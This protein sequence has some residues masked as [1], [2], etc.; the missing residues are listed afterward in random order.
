MKKNDYILL[1]S[2]VFYTLLL[3][4]QLPGINFLILNILLIGFLLWRNLTLLK[5]TNWVLTAIGSIATA[6]CITWHGNFL[7][8]L[9][10]IISLS[11]LSGLSFNTRSSVIFSFLF[12]VY[13]YFSS[14]V[15]MALAYID[16]RRKIE[17]EKTETNA[18]Y[19][20][21]L[22]LGIPVVIFLI[23]FFMY[24]AANPVFNSFAEKLNLDFISLDWIR[25]TLG[26][27]VLMYGFWYHKE[28]P[29]LASKDAS[30][31][32][33]IHPGQLGKPSFLGKILGLANENL[34]GIILLSLLILLL[35]TVNVLDIQY[36]FLG[37][38]LPETLSYSEFVH[39]GIGMLITSII[40]AILIILYYFRGNLN[41]FENNK[42][43]KLLAYLWII[44]NAFMIISTAYRNN[45]YI[46]EYSLTYKRIGVYIYL[47]LALIGL[48]TTLIK[49]AKVK[50]NW[51]LFR[52]NSWMFYAVLVISCF[53][54]WDLLITNFNINRAEKSGKFLDKDYL[55]KLSYTNIP[56][57][58]KMSDTVTSFNSNYIY[59]DEAYID[60][61]ENQNFYEQAQN[62]DAGIEKFR[63]LVHSKL[64]AFFSE[65]NQ[66]DWRSWSYDRSKT[67]KDIKELVKKVNFESVNLS[68]NN[69]TTIDPFKDFTQ[70]REINFANNQLSQL[71]SLSYFSNL[72]KLD[73][74]NNQIDSLTTLPVLNKLEELNLS[75]NSF[76]DLTP[77]K[78]A[79]A[80]RDLNIANNKNYNLN[81]IFPKMPDLKS[82]DISGNRITDLKQLNN[83]PNL[84]K[85]VINDNPE[86]NLQEIPVL[87]N[88]KVLHLK[89]S[90]ISSDNFDIRNKIKVFKNLRELNISNNNLVTI[91]Y[92]NENYQSYQDYLKDSSAL[93][94]KNF[95]PVFPDLEVLNISSNKLNKI[96]GIDA[97]KK[98]KTLNLQNTE[99]TKLEPLAL[100]PELKNLDVSYNSISIIEPLRTMT[101]LE[102]LNLS[103]NLVIVPENIFAYHFK[104]S[105]LNLSHTN[106]GKINYISGTPAL[107]V[108]NV[109]NTYLTSLEGI[110]NI[111][112]IEIL[113]ISG[114]NISDF[115]PL[116][117]LKNLKELYIGKITD[118]QL[119][120]LK[121]M[122]PK[123]KIFHINR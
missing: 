116:Y 14:I 100:L 32:N 45:L 103:H 35:L 40:C 8:F 113:D 117:K 31:T 51:Y 49:I 1:I 106:L 111:K 88:L 48:A 82:L 77:L 44:Q 75:A 43:L 20:K 22:M 73:L 123:L 104:L 33:T 46:Q 78:N 83:T 71:S 86:Q 79:P 10:N 64:Y 2:V 11:I 42:A 97:F 67:E 16:K 95:I 53:I 58:L 7:S 29:L 57:M 96:S 55:L 121:Q 24:R 37:G 56:V 101:Q 99:I 28:I 9:G 52:K 74:T 92:F 17:K 34:S 72:K 114:N 19:I 13:S 108:L 61:A 81:Y 112:T 90:N 18:S 26:G 41:F 60:T 54:S 15:Y 47:L 38:K 94:V 76:Q 50:S 39:Q 84:E 120:K 102:T 6:F 98:I 21:I 119:T 93:A 4:N 105:K 87:K 59:N 5:N 89:N 80:L 109:S 70:L 12:S 107:K 69:Y 23:F 118:D 63:N 122:L 85:L 36:L 25:F 3:F 65:Q 110:E 66:V 62:E 91:N 115:T 27:V 68:G 30:A